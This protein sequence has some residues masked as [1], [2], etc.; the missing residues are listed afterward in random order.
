MSNIIEVNHVSVTYKIMEGC[1][2]TLKD[3][4]IS[5]MK[6]KVK[7]TLF[8]A[9][10]DVTF[11]IQPGEVVGI[12]GEN[13]AGKS[14]LL[15]AVSGIFKPNKGYVHTNGSIV[16]LIELGCGFDSELTGYENIYLN[17]SILGF[18]KSFIDEKIKDI[19]EFSELG[20]FIYQPLRTY[21]SGMMM[22]LGFA[23][24]VISKPDILIVDEILAVKLYNE[25]VSLS[26]EFDRFNER[27]N[28]SFIC[29]PHFRVCEGIV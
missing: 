16:P 15:K 3:F 18:S 1:S 6:R 23:I 26:I 17:G 12:I 19:I 7:F 5:L 27:W 14:T 8:H 13:G 24:A 10:N 20:N 4:V 2:N 29:F 25:L 22:R 9:L 11:T 28:D 21:S